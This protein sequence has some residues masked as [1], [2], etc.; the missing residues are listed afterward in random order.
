[1]GFDLE[2]P[3]NKTVAIVGESGCGKSTIANMVLRF[4]DPDAGAVSLDG[5]DLRSIN[6]QWLRM[7]VGLVSQ[8]PM[9]FPGTIFKNI[10]AGM[11]DA[12]AEQVEAAA[13]AANAHDFII[14]F[15]DGYE[16][17]VGDSGAQ[18]SGGQKQRIAI[19]RAL[20]KNPK[21]LV[22]DEATS[23]LDTV[24]ERAVQE[25]LDRAR[26]DR[27]TIII[28]HR[29]STVRDCDDIV[30]LGNQGIR[31]RG[32]HESLLAMN[33]VY[34]AMIEAQQMSDSVEGGCA[35]DGKSAEDKSFGNSGTSGKDKKEKSD[36]ELEKEKEDELDEE[37][38]K[39]IEIGSTFKWA[40]RLSKV[41][42][43]SASIA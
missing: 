17:D 10:A 21:I 26:S 22:L 16:T 42:H 40:N 28:A 39:D 1:M 24:S 8:Q 36:E 15:P 13:K 35:E 23:A 33:G 25:A 4:Y 9:L 43:S 41:P 11:M 12:T 6:V 30:V 14:S 29:L 20:I 37:E 32:T 34:S 38:L 18:L 7:H 2:I 31:E 27:T 5:T 3:A 19:A